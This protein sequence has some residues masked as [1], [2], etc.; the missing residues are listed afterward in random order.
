MEEE[1]VKG[2]LII[3]GGAEDKYGE[4]KILKKVVEIIGS[5]K[6]DLVILTTATENPEDVGAEYKKIFTRLGVSKVEILNI[7]TRDDANNDSNAEIIRNSTGIFMT[8]GDQLRITS[9]LGGTKVYSAIQETYRKGVAIIG[10]S[11]GASAMSNTMIVNGMDNDPARKCTLKMAPGLGLLED[12]I[13]D[14]HFAQRGRI[15]R[16]L[17]G[18]AE[19]PYM[20]GIG[21]DEDTAIIVYPDAHF[22][23]IGTNAVTVIDGKSIK[24]SNVSELKPDEILAITNITLHVLPEGYGYEMKK[25]EVMRIKQ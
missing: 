5:D 2:N 23:V 22:E 18:V 3:I 11:A 12:A 20:L 25:R 21:I 6:A 14:Q 9:I 24:S 7:D 16:L 19:N 4:S 1:I 15:G 10:T 13:I 17:C 8:G